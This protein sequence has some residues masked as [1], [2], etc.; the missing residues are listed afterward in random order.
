MP[1]PSP[2]KVQDQSP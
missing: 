2:A 1:H